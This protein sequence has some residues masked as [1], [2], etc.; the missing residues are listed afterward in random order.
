MLVGRLDMDKL[1][2]ARR[3]KKYFPVSGGI[4]SRGGEVVH[5]VEGVDLD[6]A[7][8]EVVGLVGESGCGKSTIGRLLIRL[9]EPT[10]GSVIFKDEDIFKADRERLKRLRREFQI[11]FQDPYASLDPRMR[12]GATLEEPLIIHRIGNKNERREKVIRLLEGVRMS[13]DSIYRYPHEFSG[14]E[15]QRIGIARALALDPKFIVADE[16]ISSLDVSIQAQVIN[17]LE[18]LQEEYSLSILFISHDL[19]MIRHIADRVAVMYLGRIVEL[20]DNNELYSHPLHPYTE[21]LLSAIPI[22]DPETKRKRIILEGDLPSPIDLPPGCPFYSRCP[23]RID[24]CKQV[25]P[26]LRELYPNHFVA[27]HVAR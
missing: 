6:I 5:A 20:A 4:F 7:R 18:D 12:I 19:N 14:G 2:T 16:P 25:E 11:I 9:I 8:G 17:L 22:P 21:A 1:I 10:D 3:L 24:I 27:C 13:P 15:R 26:E 23:K